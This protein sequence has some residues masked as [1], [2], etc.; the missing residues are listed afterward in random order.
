MPPRTLNPAFRGGGGLAHKGGDQGLKNVIVRS[1]E[2]GCLN[3]AGR[4]LTECPSEMQHLDSLDYDGKTWWQEVE[5]TKIDLNYN[6][7]ASLPE[8][9]HE[10]PMLGSV[11]VV[12]R[13]GGTR[14]AGDHRH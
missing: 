14:A 2:T 3:L 4:K 8:N 7:L 6:S 13:P 5:L 1:L 9:F 10:L 11:Q 12:Q